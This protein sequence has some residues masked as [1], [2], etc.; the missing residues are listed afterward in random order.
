MTVYCFCVLVYCLCLQGPLGEVL[1]VEIACIARKQE[2]VV[3][4]TVPD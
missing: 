2:G 1:K 4:M 3:E